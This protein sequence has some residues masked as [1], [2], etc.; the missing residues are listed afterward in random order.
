MRHLEARQQKKKERLAGHLAVRVKAMER[1]PEVI[2]GV[3]GFPKEW[4]SAEA[5]AKIKN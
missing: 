3:R 2:G 4:L 1:R 5:Q